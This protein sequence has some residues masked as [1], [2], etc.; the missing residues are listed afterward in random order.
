MWGTSGPGGLSR[1]QVDVEATQGASLSPPPS[2]LSP[3]RNWDV[4]SQD[5][6]S[7][8]GFSTLELRLLSD[9]WEP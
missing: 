8:T 6:G 2:L 5:S 9:S 7:A 1:P 3:C 4:L